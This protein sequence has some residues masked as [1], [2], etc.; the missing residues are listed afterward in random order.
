MHPSAFVLQF[1]AQTFFQNRI[2][3]KSCFQDIR[4][5]SKFNFS[6]SNLM[7]P[8]SYTV[9]MG[10]IVSS[11]NK[12]WVFF[13]NC[14][15][16]IVGAH[17]K[18]MMSVHVINEQIGKVFQYFPSLEKASTQMFHHQAQEVLMINSFY[19]TARRRCFTDVVMMVF[20]F[21]S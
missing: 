4:S 12:T 10:L 7:R 2:P 21:H 17:Q 13:T 20:G 3:E 9:L 8:F 1:L 6:V 5:P 11:G 14:G 15:S 18:V 19:F 16:C